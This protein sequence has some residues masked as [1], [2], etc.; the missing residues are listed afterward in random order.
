MTEPNL[1][2]AVL[3][4]DVEAVRNLLE[5]GAVDIKEKGG[6]NHSTALQLSV[7]MSRNPAIVELLM[8]HTARENIDD[9]FNGGTLLHHVI[10]FRNMPLANILLRFGVDIE[11]KDLRGETPLNLAV[12]IGADEFALLLLQTGADVNARQTRDGFTPLISAAFEGRENLVNMLLMYGADISM[13]DYESD[14]SAE[15]WA[16]VRGYHDIKNVIRDR[17]LGRSGWLRM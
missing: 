3:N 7:S 17:R 13:R 5:V 6:N 14:L 11:K 1:W 9:I 4:D 10:T 8:L 2:K 16:E 12:G 15:N